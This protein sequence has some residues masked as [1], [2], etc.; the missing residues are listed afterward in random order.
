[1]TRLLCSSA[2]LLSA[3]AWS[4]EPDV[5]PW[6]GAVTLTD[7]KGQ[8]LTWTVERIDGEV[9]ITGTHPKWQV[10]H[11]A[12]PDG[13]PL[14][15]VKKAGGNTTRV[16]YSATGAVVERTDARG[17]TSSATVKEKHLWDGDTLDAR[18]AGTTWTAG[19]KVQMRIVAIDEADGST[20]PMVAEYVGAES[21]GGVP[22]HHV[23]LA[24][25]DFRRMFAP[26][27]EYRYAT[28]PGAKYLQH[29]GD[30]LTFTAR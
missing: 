9:H 25:D 14:T 13:T 12:K 22:C 30:D 15:T 26:S 5:F 28:S 16:T 10:E 19:K 4:A 29:D 2:L 27:F 17:K 18:L 7:P 20:Y 8:K 24:L 1:M 6:N 23:H 21:C 3:L 11:H